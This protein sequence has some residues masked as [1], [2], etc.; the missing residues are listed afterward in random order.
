MRPFRT[1]ALAR[2]TRLLATVALAL[3]AA[4]CSSSQVSAPEGQ[5]TVTGE[6]LEIMD[7]TPVDGGVTI[8]ILVPTPDDAQEVL[9]F[10]SLFTNPPPSAQRLEVYQRIQAAQVGSVVW[11][12]GV[13]TTDG[14][15]LSDFRV[16]TP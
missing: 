3:V 10:G 14:I 5:I 7:Q 8:T 6:V 16:L 2:G 4:A 13:R 12:E 9:L 15:V 1:D 11:A